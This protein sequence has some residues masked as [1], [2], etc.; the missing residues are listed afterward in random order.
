MRTVHDVAQRSP[1][2][3]ALRIGKLCGSR[4]S[5]M[6][7]TRRDSKPSASRTNLL[8]QLVLERVTGKSQERTFQSQA[9]LDGIE[10]EA[11]AA[12]AYEVRTG[13]ILQPVG[14]VSLDGHLAGCSPDGEVNDFEGLIEVKCPIAATHYEFLETG[15]IPND[16]LTQITHNLWVTGA[17][18]CD[19]VSFH[20]DF[21]AHLRIQISRV[22]RE[23]LGLP[24]YEKAA[25]TFL[26]EVET[27]AAAMQ[28]REAV[29]V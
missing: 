11:D 3:H 20:P 14:F 8:M 28:A 5:D 18:W 9:M 7:A 27:K 17:Q 22:Q 29:G 24:A 26:A 19:Y 2:W 15:L 23:Y 25:L 21:P 10:R 13:K 6:I 4:A 16:Y 1:E 12:A